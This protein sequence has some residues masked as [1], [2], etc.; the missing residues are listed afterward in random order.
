MASIL[1]AYFSLACPFV[2][3]GTMDPTKFAGLVNRDGVFDMLLLSFDSLLLLQLF[4]ESPNRKPIPLDCSPPVTLSLQFCFDFLS[5]VFCHLSDDSHRQATSFRRLSHGHSTRRCCACFDDALGLSLPVKG[6]WLPISIRAIESV[7]SLASQNRDAV[8]MPVVS[9]LVRDSNVFL[10]GAGGQIPFP[11]R[12]LLALGLLVSLGLGAVVLGAGA[13]QFFF[14]VQIGAN[15]FAH[16]ESPHFEVRHL[17]S[18]PKV[19]RDA[20]L[21]TELSSCLVAINKHIPKILKGAGVL[22]SGRPLD[23]GNRT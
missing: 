5:V 12:C 14:V 1:A 4:P 16:H 3:R 7:R 8:G 2:N 20:G 19:A 10:E 13:G 23:D 6:C 15:H 9:R 22:G 17:A 18:F 21:Q 11:V